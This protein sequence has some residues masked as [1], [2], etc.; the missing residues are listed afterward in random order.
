MLQWRLEDK[1]KILTTLVLKL[2][3]SAVEG[4]IP[5]LPAHLLFMCLRY[6]DHVQNEHQVTMLLE[7]IIKGVQQVCSVCVCVCVT[8]FHSIIL[9]IT[10]CG[11]HI[12]VVQKNVNNIDMLSFWLANI[13][14][15]FHNLK[16]YSGDEVCVLLPFVLLLL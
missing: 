11:L 10:I 13:C 4:Q 9:Y 12:Q 2:H 16:Q 3:P 8:H 1:D 7:G 15:L 6:A 5:C 14:R